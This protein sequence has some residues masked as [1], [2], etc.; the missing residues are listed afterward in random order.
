MSPRGCGAALCMAAAF[1][2]SSCTFPGPSRSPA[3]INEAFLRRPDVVITL[4]G[5]GSGT[6]VVENRG[7]P[8][9]WADRDYGPADLYPVSFT[10][11]GSQFPNLM[12]SLRLIAR[13]DPLQQ[14]V[15]RAPNSGRS[16][17]VA[18]AHSRLLPYVLNEVTTRPGELTPVLLIRRPHF[19]VGLLSNYL[20]LFVERERCPEARS[21]YVL[22]TT[23]FRVQ[24]IAEATNVAGR[25][26]E[27]G[28]AF[29]AGPDT[30]YG[31]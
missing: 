10:V 4:Q 12:R 28:I 23:Q 16:Y 2:V 9:V 15:Y 20:M 17:T 24:M 8:F 21:P 25:K 19:R 27:A 1:L 26:S 31:W 14:C 5:G 30:G 11:T 6:I 13:P 29:R 18:A 7:K 22:D 3:Q